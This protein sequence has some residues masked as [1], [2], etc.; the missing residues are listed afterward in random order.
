MSPRKYPTRME[1]SRWGVPLELAR[2]LSRAFGLRVAIETGTYQAQSALELQDIF[3]RVYT[4]ELSEELYRLAVETHGHHENVQFLQGSSP[5]VLATVLG[6]TDEPA[7]FWLDAHWGGSEGAGENQQCPVLAE[8]RV[9]DGWQHAASS[10]ILID[11]ARWFLT[12]PHPLLRR[13]DWP[14]FLEVLDLLRER[15]D[16]YVTVIEDV[17]IAGPREILAVLDE[18][19]LRVQWRSLEDE[20]RSIGEAELRALDPPPRVAARLLVKSLLPDRVRAWYRRARGRVSANP[21]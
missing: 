1:S 16:R 5:E 12:R 13:Q 7:L 6:Q 11:D 2:D 4:I 10:C 20:S 14:T 18:Y 21:S 15:H 8:V 19:S 9:I 3:E 17:V